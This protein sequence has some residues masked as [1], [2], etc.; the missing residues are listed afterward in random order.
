MCCFRR[1]FP[2]HTARSAPP[3]SLSRP[4][5]KLGSDPPAIGALVA[6]I[7]PQRP[8]LPLKCGFSLLGA[9]V[10]PPTSFVNRVC[11]DG[12]AGTFARRTRPEVN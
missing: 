2:G 7:S 8:Q 4:S 9:M 6:I 1:C 3:G 12:R 5:D 11:V 10:H